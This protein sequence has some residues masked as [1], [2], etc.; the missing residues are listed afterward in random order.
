VFLAREDL[1]EMLPQ[2]GFDVVVPEAVI[3]EIRAHGL[4]DP[5]VVAIGRVGWLAAVSAISVPP[6]VARWNLG[7]GESAVLALAMAEPGAIVV[8]DD[9]GARR[10]ARSLEIPL[11]G[12]LGLVLRAKRKGRIPEARPVVER[13]RGSGMYLSDQVIK[14]ALALVGE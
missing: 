9:Q 6:E 3:E 14:E 1:L 11:I 12:T 4:A 13:L 8:I 7:P 10:C 2:G 5:T